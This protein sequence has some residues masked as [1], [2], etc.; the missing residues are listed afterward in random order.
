MG[1]AVAGVAVHALFHRCTPQRLRSAGPRLLTVVAAATAPDLDLL[2]RFVDGR[3]HHQDESHSLGAAA[4]CAAVVL[5][6]ALWRRV[7][8]PGLLAAAAGLAWSSH[9]LLDWLAVDTTPPI[10][11]MALWPLSHDHYHCP[12]SLF[13]AV[14]RNLSVATVRHDLVAFAWEMTLLVPIAFAC[15]PR[16]RR[17]P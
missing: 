13:L 9:V 14:G 1:H 10:G 2:A 5:V 11:I 12:G 4:V 8:A 16:R 6:A 15:W 7:P 17:T 3:N